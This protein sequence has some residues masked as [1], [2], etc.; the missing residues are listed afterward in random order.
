[1]RR[2]RRPSVPGASVLRPYTIRP[3]SW[4]RQRR[5]PLLEAL[6]LRIR[7]VL[8]IE[9]VV[10]HACAAQPGSRALVNQEARRRAG[11]GVE[12]VLVDAHALLRAGTTGP[13]HDPH[14]A[15]RDAR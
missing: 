9:R 12:V 11:V 13:G 1:Q 15:R 4:R 7:E 10:G 6:L 2:R 8:A 3:R 5:R 14:E